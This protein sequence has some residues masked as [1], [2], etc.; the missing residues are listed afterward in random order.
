MEQKFYL[1]NDATGFANGD[2]F[3]SDEQVRDYFTAESIKMMFGRCD[4][5]DDVLREYANAV[6]ANRWHYDDSPAGQ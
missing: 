4:M 3:T 2:R 5:P 6:I 1:I